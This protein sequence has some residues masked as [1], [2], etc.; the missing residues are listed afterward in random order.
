V[1]VPEHVGLTVPSQLS[2]RPLQVSALA[3]AFAVQLPQLPLLQRC[4][5]AAHDPRMPVSQPCD[6]PA[7][8]TSLQVGPLKLP[9][10]AQL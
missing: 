4:V 3:V 9:T 5:P 7:A 6:A 8:H 1:A 10:Q 2:S